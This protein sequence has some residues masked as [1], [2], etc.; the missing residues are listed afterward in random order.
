MSF[1]S[2]CS[3]IYYILMIKNCDQCK[4]SPAFGHYL[5]VW[6]VWRHGVSEFKRVDPRWIQAL[7]NLGYIKTF[8]RQPISDDTS[9]KTLS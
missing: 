8:I 5:F 2:P 6:C 3:P 1:F 7:P 9:Q 4:L